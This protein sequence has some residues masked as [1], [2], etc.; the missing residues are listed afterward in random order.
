MVVKGR[1]DRAE[2]LAALWKLGGGGDLP[3]GG[4]RLDLAL[5]V[6]AGLLSSLLPGLTF[7]TTAVGRRCLELPDIILAGEEALLFETISPSFD[8]AIVKL[9]MDETVEIVLSAGMTVSQATS[10]GR[11]IVAVVMDEA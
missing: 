10:I 2:G 3:L 1:F 8:R 5:E 11:A 9:G 6:N 7:S 4:G